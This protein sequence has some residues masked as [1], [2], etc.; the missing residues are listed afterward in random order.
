MAIV[1]LNLFAAAALLIQPPDFATFFVVYLLSV[2][3]ER[4]I[5]QPMPSLLAARGRLAV[6]ASVYLSTSLALAAA[7]WYTPLVLL[8]PLLA[9]LR[10]RLDM[11]LPGVAALAVLSPGSATA[12][13]VFEVLARSKPVA[14][15]GR[16]D[17][18]I[19]TLHP[20]FKAL[21]AA[22]F[23][24]AYLALSGVPN[25]EIHGL[26]TVALYNTCHLTATHHLAVSVFIAASYGV[27]LGAALDT[28]LDSYL[29][30]YHFLRR[31]LS[32]K[33]LL[34]LAWLLAVTSPVCLFAA[35]DVLSHMTFLVL[36]AALTWSFKFNLFK[37]EDAALLLVGLFVIS[38]LY[39]SPWALAAA[40]IL[41]ALPWLAERIRHLLSTSQ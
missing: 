20:A 40:A 10:R 30:V 22:S 18:K 19:S 14:T 8:A 39:R 33:P 41:P 27:V 15:M 4:G 21:L 25:V 16:G 36:L 24:F 34:T 38:F 35:C 31:R 23:L 5:G 29:R 37:N 9:T 11:F 28:Y 2:Y 32:A 3:V 17:L 7:A 13:A 26:A 6:A 12:V 1:L